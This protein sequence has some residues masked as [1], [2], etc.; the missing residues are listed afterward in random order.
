MTLEVNEVRPARICVATEEMIEAH[1]V[2]RGRRGKCPDV[3]HGR[4]V[5]RNVLQFT[6]NGT[7]RRC[8]RRVW[9]RSGPMRPFDV[10]QS[11]L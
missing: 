7:E 2:Q 8:R 4:R 6:R 1:V 3:S 9:Y 10:R 5:A 11:S